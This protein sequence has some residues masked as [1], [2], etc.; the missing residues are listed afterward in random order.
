MIKINQ[1]SEMIYNVMRDR[2]KINNHTSMK[3]WLLYLSALWREAETS[4]HDREC[5]RFVY[6]HLELILADM[7]L[8]I[9][10]LL[11][12]L[13]VKNIENLLR[14]RIDENDRKNKMKL[15]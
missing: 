15:K 8:L 12:R 5:S 9:V 4:T 2:F 14:R 7:I 3:A 6:S 10:A 13:G 11:H 1:L